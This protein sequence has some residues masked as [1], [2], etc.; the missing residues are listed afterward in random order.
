MVQM[1]C[2]IHWMCMPSSTVRISDVFALLLRSTKKWQRIVLMFVKCTRSVQSADY[3][4]EASDS[5]S[6]SNRTE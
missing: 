3:A 5:L 6:V 1:S 4:P 2:E